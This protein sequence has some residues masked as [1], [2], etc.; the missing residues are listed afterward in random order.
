T[1]LEHFSARPEE[2]PPL[3]QILEVAGASQRLALGEEVIAE[4][5]WNYGPSS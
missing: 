5:P 4:R 3:D 1:T 2:D